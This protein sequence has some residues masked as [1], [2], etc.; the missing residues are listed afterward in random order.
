MFV[1]L[2][3]LAIAMLQIESSLQVFATDF[4]AALQNNCALLSPSEFQ[5]R[6][7][8]AAVVCGVKPAANSEYRLLQLTGLLHIVVVSGSHLVFLEQ[9]LSALFDRFKFTLIVK[10]IVLTGFALMTGFQPP[11]VRALC[12]QLLNHFQS[13]KKLFWSPPAVTLFAGL[14][15]LII[16][17]NWWKSISLQLSWVA[18]LCL[19]IPTDGKHLS[20]RIKQQLCIFVL[21]FPLLMQFAP[22]HPVS[23]IYNLIAAPFIGVVMFPASAA[24]MLFPNALNFIDYLWSWFFNFLEFSV[25]RSSALEPIKL[26][27]LAFIWAYVFAINIFFIIREQRR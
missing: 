14:I 3:L 5:N 24:A 4:S 23:I 8:I 10:I 9:I 17:P 25:P 13:S 16:A 7:W 19:Q 26:G 15:T 21:M 12:S 11:V 6:E 1:L 20:R 22:P 27:S 18:S 2:S